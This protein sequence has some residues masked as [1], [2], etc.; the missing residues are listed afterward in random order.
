M[1]LTVLAGHP[2]ATSF[3]AALIAA[4]VA[5]AERA[6]ATVEVI[7]VST[8]QF[9]PVLRQ[10][11][12]ASS[13]AEAL[14]DEEPD[15]ARVRASLLQ[16]SHLTFVFPVWW[17]GLPA[18]LKALVDRV[19]LPGWAFR[20]GDSPLPVGLLGGRSARYVATM[21]SPA[22][23]YHLVQKD[24]LGGSFGRGTLRFVGLSP[25]TRTLI[26]GVRS[27]NEPARKRWLVRLEETGRRDVEAR[28]RRPALVLGPTEP[29]LALGAAAAHGGPSNLT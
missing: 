25:V 3:N 11:H 24:A 14:H 20:Y 29:R 10:A 26:H 16:S 9:D 8:L 19:F 2:Q 18:A 5:G 7:D 21:D 28:L 17:V 22:L 23:W 12:G 6:G 15:L 1:H 13:L 4:Y 27:L